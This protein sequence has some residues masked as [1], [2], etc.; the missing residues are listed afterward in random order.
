[1]DTDAV[2]EVIGKPYAER[3]YTLF[4]REV[5][6]GEKPLSKTV[7]HHRAQLQ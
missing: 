4:M 2:V 1:M 6:D 5:A 7:V 3:N